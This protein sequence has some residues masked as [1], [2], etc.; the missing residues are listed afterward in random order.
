MSTPSE[1]SWKKGSASYREPYTICFE[2]LKSHTEKDE[3][4][5]GLLVEDSKD[6]K[7]TEANMNFLIEE[8]VVAHILRQ[9]LVDL[10]RTLTRSDA[11]RLIAYPGKPL[12]SDVYQWKNALLSKKDAGNPFGGAQYDLTEKR[13]VIFDE[14]SI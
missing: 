4:F 11:W 2:T 13:L 12:A 14:V 3:V 8:I 7:H 6:R 9:K 10:P 1:I 5:H